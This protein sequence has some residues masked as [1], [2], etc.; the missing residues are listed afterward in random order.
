MTVEPGAPGGQPDWVGY[1][2]C[3]KD[4]AIWA[5]GSMAAQAGIDQDSPRWTVQVGPMAGPLVTWQVVK[6]YYVGTARG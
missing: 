5:P 6:A 2:Y 1:F 4:G 3:R